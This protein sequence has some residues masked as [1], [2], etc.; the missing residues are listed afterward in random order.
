GA[1]ARPAEVGTT[2]GEKLRDE[3]ELAPDGRL[4]VDLDPGADP[5]STTDEAPR[6]RPAEADR[7]VLP[8]RD[9]LVVEVEREL[10][11]REHMHI[12]QPPPARPELGVQTPAE[13]FVLA[14]RGGV[15][16][17]QPLLGG[18]V[19]VDPGKDLGGVAHDPLGRDEHGHRD[20]APG[21]PRSELV[22]ALDVALLAIWD[23]GAL[24]RPAGLLAVVADRDRDEAQHRGRLQRTSGSCATTALL[25]AG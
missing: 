17:E 4:V 12:H 14:T 18:G 20:P 3:V 8:A 5:E 22:D 24:Q 15:R 11:L 23:P 19:L 21:A 16:G 10:G 2:V 13:S 25:R 1:E 6:E 9:A 7:A